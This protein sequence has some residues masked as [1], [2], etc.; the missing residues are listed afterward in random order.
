MGLC[1]EDLSA[2]LKF[3]GEQSPNEHVSSIH[4]HV[5]DQ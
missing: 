2:N 1:S 3:D 5:S 4:A